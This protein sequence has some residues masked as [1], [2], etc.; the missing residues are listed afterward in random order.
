MM[1]TAIQITRPVSLKAVG[2]AKIITNA[3]AIGM[4]LAAIHVRRRP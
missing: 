2:G 4:T 3:P 1:A